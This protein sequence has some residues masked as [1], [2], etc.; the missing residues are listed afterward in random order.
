[1]PDTSP[2]HLAFDHTCLK[3]LSVCFLYR[4]MLYCI[5]QVDKSRS[6]GGP[7]QETFAGGR[8][9]S[10]GGGRWR[11]SPSPGAVEDIRTSS[12]RAL[13]QHSPVKGRTVSPLPFS[14]RD[15]QHRRPAEGRRGS[16]RIGGPLV[17]SSSSSSSRMGNSLRAFAPPLISPVGV[18]SPGLGYAGLVRGAAMPAR[19][20]GMGT[21]S[22]GAARGMGSGTLALGAAAGGSGIGG[23]GK[24]GGDGRSGGR[25]DRP[26]SSGTGSLAVL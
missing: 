3:L 2:C 8:D 18:A 19:Q 22:A 5:H 10:D 9:D 16:R 25:R 12:A 11:P 26:P 24:R 23:G 17:A 7:P 14:S 21:L 20:G 13:N 6:S 4:T 15:K 1:M